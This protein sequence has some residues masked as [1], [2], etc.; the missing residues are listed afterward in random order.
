MIKAGLYSLILIMGFVCSA[1]A[2]LR[3][4]AVTDVSLEGYN[5]A[6]FQ[7]ALP[8]L[9]KSCMHLDK[10]ERKNKNDRLSFYVSTTL[11]EICPI[12][13][14][15]APIEDVWEFWQDQVRLYRVADGDVS[16]TG[17]FTGYYQPILQG[18]KERGGAYQYPLYALPPDFKTPYYTR[19]EIEAGKI[20]PKTEVLAWLKSPIDAFFLHVQGSG[21]VTYEDGDEAFFGFRAKN[22]HS[23]TSIG[24]YLIAENYLTKEEMSKEALEKWLTEHPDQ[25]QFVLNQNASYIFFQRSKVEAAVGSVGVPLTPAHNLAIDPEYIPYGSLLWLEADDEVPDQTDVKIRD[26]FVALDT[27]SAIKGAVRGDVFWGRGAEAG[28]KAGQMKNRGQYYLF[29]SSR[30]TEKDLKG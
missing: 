13:N 7:R 17:L 21:L 12:V 15:N 10:I 28:K 5:E 16:S 27:G 4:E 18:A 6:A 11:Q 14:S 23:Y 25:L 24:Q 2:E 20:H 3:L 26:L 1:M 29:L 22:G 9:K 30:F 19:A 8:A